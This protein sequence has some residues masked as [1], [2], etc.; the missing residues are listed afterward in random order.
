MIDADKLLASLHGAEE[1]YRQEF[2]E[3]AG[4]IADGNATPHDVTELAFIQRDRILLAR[5]VKAVEEAI[6]P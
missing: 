1:R 5:I 4:R 6:T 3:I 2:H